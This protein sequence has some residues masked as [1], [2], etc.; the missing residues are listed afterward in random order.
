MPSRTM[1]WPTTPETKSPLSTF[2]SST[3]ANF[4][5]FGFACICDHV[6]EVVL[7]HAE[8]VE[9][10][11]EDLDVARLVEGLRREEALAR[12]VGCG[13]DQPRRSGERAALTDD[14][15]DRRADRFFA[16]RRVLEH[17]VR[18][19]LAG[20]V[21][22]FGV[23]QIGLWAGFEPGLDRVGIQEIRH[24]SLLRSAPCRAGKVRSAGSRPGGSSRAFG[25]RNVQVAYQN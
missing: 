23:L 21:S 2:S 19:L 11:R 22:V 17:E 24:R 1:F 20:R 16:H 7:L 9:P 13:V 25:V 18:L 12:V 4:T 8:V 15:L 5:R 14:Q 6:L 3:S 10:L